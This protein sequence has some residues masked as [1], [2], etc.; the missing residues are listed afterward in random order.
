MVE[1]TT[2][3]VFIMKKKS[4][5]LFIVVLI[6]I[7]LL[8]AC[9]STEQSSSLENNISEESNNVENNNSGNDNDHNSTNN[10]QQ[11]MPEKPGQLTVWVHIEEKQVEAVNKI[12]ENY[13]EETGIEVEVIPVDQPSQVE[14]LNLEGP[15]GNGPDIIIQPHDNIGDL[16]LR[17]IIDEVNLDDVKSEYTDTAVNSVTF[18]GS[19]WGYPAAIETYTMYYNKSLVDKTPETFEELM[20]IAEERTNPANDEFGFLMEATNFYYMKSFFG[21]YGAYIFGENN[22][23]YDVTDIGLNNEGA[24]EAGKLIQSWFEKGYIPHDLTQ[25]V[26]N[27]LFKE[28]KVVAVINGPWMLREYEEA[29]GDDLGAVT[30]P[31]LDN[32]EVPKSFVGVKLYMLSYYSEN[33]EWA[34]DLMRYMTNEENSLLYYELSGEIPARD[35]V[36][37]DPLI[38]DNELTSAFAEQTSYGEPMPS[39]PAMQQVWGPINDGLTFISQGDPVDEVLEDVVTFIKEQIEATGATE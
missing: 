22:G 14:K 19:Y 33:K 30:L 2:Q 27:G 21:G 9:G 3:E 6:S 5:L 12:T 36:V 1:I 17:G 23:E 31:R 10:D 13:T 29:L 7:G 20:E 32:G 38:A 37:Q 34:E 39:I 28:G 11:D 4:I 15:A 35:D 18:D 24:V 16:V 8:A 25:D 26:M